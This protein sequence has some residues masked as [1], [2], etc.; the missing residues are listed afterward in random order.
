MASETFSDRLWRAVARMKRLDD[1]DVAFVAA[2]FT[3]VLSGDQDSLDEALGLR[4]GPGQRSLKTRRQISERDD[5]FRRAV[6]EFLPGPSKARQARQVHRALS[7]YEATA[8]R[9]GERDKVACPPQHAGTVKALAWEILHL[10][11][12]G[13][14]T[15]ASETLRDTAGRVERGEFPEPTHP[16]GNA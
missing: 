14:R 2:G 8:W 12:V 6:R 13:G 1:P 15:A 11:Y 16:A 4:P 5:L 3:S 7:R 10:T 9:R